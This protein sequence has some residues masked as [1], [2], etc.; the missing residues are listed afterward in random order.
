MI[1]K[2]RNIGKSHPL[3]AKFEDALTKEGMN[4]LKVSPSKKSGSSLASLGRAFRFN[5][6]EKRDDLHYNP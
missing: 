6:A 2:Y 4:K 3:L 5:V 1:Y